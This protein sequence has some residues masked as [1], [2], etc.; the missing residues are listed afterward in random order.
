MNTKTQKPLA[1][2]RPEIFGDVA[3]KDQILMVNN[4]ILFLFFFF[5]YKK[6]I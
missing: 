4:E 6:F 1:Q 2:L 5:L 3:V